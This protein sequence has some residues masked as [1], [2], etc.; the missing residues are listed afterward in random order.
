LYIIKSITNTINLIL[1]QKLLQAEYLQILRFVKNIG[2]FNNYLIATTQK[3]PLFVKENHLNTLVD[4]TDTESNVMLLS[5]R[6]LDSPQLQLAFLLSPQIGIVSTSTFPLTV[7]NEDIPFDRYLLQSILSNLLQ[8]TVIFIGYI[9]TLNESISQYLGVLSI[10]PSN[11]QTNVPFESINIEQ[12]NTLTS[13]S[14]NLTNVVTK[15][16][17]VVSY[18]MFETFVKTEINNRLFTF[19]YLIQ[20]SISPSRYKQPISFILKPKVH[21][22]TSPFGIYF[23]TRTYSHSNL[24]RYS[25]LSV[26]NVRTYVTMREFTLCNA[27]KIIGNGFSPDECNAMETRMRAVRNGSYY[28]PADKNLWID[29]LLSI[30]VDALYRLHESD[31]EAITNYYRIKLEAGYAVWQMN[32]DETVSKLYWEWDDN[33]RASV[34]KILEYLGA[35]LENYI[36]MPIEIQGCTIEHLILYCELG[37]PTY[38][39]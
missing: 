14:V 12:K 16:Y 13:I 38:D 34:H 18:L 4:S 7:P 11:K 3:Q 35:A 24:N 19:L 27:M 9:I 17:D 2:L 23:K 10:I 32:H 36:T 30:P 1:K 20:Y 6:P 31:H 33:D 29:T 15:Y 37:Y 28:I 22:M 21:V 25:I 8:I 26:Q 39:P 5:K